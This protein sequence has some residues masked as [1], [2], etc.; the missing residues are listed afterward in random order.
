MSSSAPSIVKAKNF[1]ADNCTYGA[2]RINKRGG[3]NVSVLY[4]GRPL[5]VQFPLTLSYGINERVDEATSRVTYDVALQ[6]GPEDETPSGILRK[7]LRELEEKILTDAVT[8]GQSWFN[9]GNMTRDV[10]SALMYPILKHPKNK[11]TGEPDLDRNPTLKLKVVY[12]DDEFKCELFDM[13]QNVL[14]SKHLDK[15]DSSPVDLVPQKSHLTGLFECQGIWFAGG[16]FGVTWK[17]LQ[18]KVR[19]P[20][21]I[22]GY[23][24]LDD[25]DEEDAVASVLQAEKE[26]RRT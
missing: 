7:G 17:L 4:E 18:A 25:S 9:K 12:W 22:Q 23:C 6:F 11:D 16:R 13:E 2:P 26:L 5:V 15:T 8:N 20:V 24:M 3:K 10:A 14:Y 21:K 1:A 19:P